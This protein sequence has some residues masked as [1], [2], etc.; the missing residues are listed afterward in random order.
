MTSLLKSALILAFS[1]G[2]MSCMKP[3]PLPAGAQGG[4]RAGRYLDAVWL[5]PDFKRSSSFAISA[6]WGETPASEGV[7]AYLDQKT[8]AL[9]DPQAPYRLILRFNRSGGPPSIGL[10][11]TGPF[12]AVHGK[13]EDGSG[14]V[15]AMFE[16]RRSTI[17]PLAANEQSAIDDTLRW[18]YIDLGPEN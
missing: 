15:L 9:T 6:A 8:R 5:C 16:N 1:A 14:H 3:E 2:L 17:F 11:R 7:R 4:Y 18:I 12:L 10:F 13:V